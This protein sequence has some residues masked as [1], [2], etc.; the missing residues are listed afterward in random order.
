MNI[1]ELISNIE[2][3]LEE[4]HKLIADLGIEADSSE[5][6]YFYAFVKEIV[7]EYA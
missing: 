6:H 2:V 3:F 7:V 5:K 4:D 1:S